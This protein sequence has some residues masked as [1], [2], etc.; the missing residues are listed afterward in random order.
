MPRKNVITIEQGIELKQSDVIATFSDKEKLEPYIEKIREAVCV[1]D[2]EVDLT[3][4]KGRDAIAS[5]AHRVS[6]MKTALTKASKDSVKDLKD[7]IT[8]VSSGTKYLEETLSALR[9]ETRAPLNEW[10]AEQKRIEEKRVADIKH[11]IDCIKDMGSI[12][13]GSTIESLSSMIEALENIDCS[14]GFDEFATE[15][16]RTI[17]QAKDSL[18]KGIQELITKESNRKFEEE[19][20]KFAAE[21]AEFERQKAEFEE[22]QR[23]MRTPATTMTATVTKPA[24]KPAKTLQQTQIEE[25]LYQHFRL[26]TQQTEDITLA[27]IEGRMPHVSFNQEKAA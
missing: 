27:I 23:A 24:K 17:G 26:T 16:L 25:Y 19:Q 20:A 12:P 18:S 8:A 13:E 5:R 1:E 10:E 3:T 14:E 6:K 21:R 4:K 7:T 2:S 22:A 9:D 11:K 15:A